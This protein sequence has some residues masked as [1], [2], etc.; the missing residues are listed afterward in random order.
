MT[1]PVD[2]SIEVRDARIDVEGA[3]ACDQLALRAAGRRLVLA[4]APS[5]AIAAAISSRGTVVSGSLLINGKDVAQGAHFGHVGIAALDLPLPHRDSIL[6]YVTVSFRLAGLSR[7]EAAAAAHAAMDDLG[8]RALETRKAP[9]LSLAERRAAV[10]AQAMLPGASVLFAEAPLA[11]LETQAAR[12]VLNVLGQACKSRSVI[13]TALR[14]DPSSPERELLLGAD[15][16]ALLSDSGTSWIGQPDALLKGV[17]LYAIVVRGNEPAFV[18]RAVAAG[19]EVRGDPPRMIVCLPEGATT[20]VL[21]D[22]A[23]ES[24]TTLLEAVA[25]WQ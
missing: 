5:A 15:C 23:R 14:S 8:L 17:R 11:G 4:G 13:A 18:E 24:D 7:T 19:V 21:L 12:Y 3:A 10:I 22:A 9:T 20:R 25:I 2:V 1:Q 16:V 6:A